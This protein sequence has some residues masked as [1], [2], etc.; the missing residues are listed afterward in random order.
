MAFYGLRQDHFTLGNGLWVYI[1]RL[2]YWKQDANSVLIVITGVITIIFGVLVYLLFPDSPLHA[3]FLTPKERAQAVL[4][5]KDNN[6]GI[7]NKL[8]KKH[9][10][11]NPV[12]SIFQLLT[13]CYRF[14]E[15]VRDPK[16]WL[17]ALHA[18]SQE[19]G[20][21]INNQTSLIINSFGFTVFQTTLLS[22]V[23]GVIAFITLSL[24]AIALYKTRVGCS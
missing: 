6:S 18:L 17:F 20:N 13:F 9:Q 24:A 15:A 1:L 4:R 12:A 8:F 7:E 5:I 16:T 14:I 3:N 22:T 23:S 2:V 21:G 10:W 11:D 19:M